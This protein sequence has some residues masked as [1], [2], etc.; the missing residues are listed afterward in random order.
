MEKN[1]ELQIMRYYADKGERFM[2][3][4]SGQDNTAH[5]G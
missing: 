3:M 5:H 2:V 4:P 1:Y